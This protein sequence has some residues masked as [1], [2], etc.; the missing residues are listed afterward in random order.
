MPPPVNG[1]ALITVRMIQTL[2]CS[3]EVEA[4]NISPGGRRGFRKHLHKA[5]QT[6]RACWRIARNESR[7]RLSYLACEGDWGL[8]YTAA[9]VATARLFGHTIFLHHHS[10][11]YID[12]FSQ[13]MRLI[14]RIGGPK[15]LHIFLCTTMRD[16]FA[17][18]YGRIERCRIV[19]NAAFVEPQPE[20]K[21]AFGLSHPLR[22]GLLSNLTQEKG[23]YT[24]IDL[25]RRLEQSNLEVHGFLAG[26]IAD[27]NDKVNVSQAEKELTGSLTYMGPVFG[28]AKDQFYRNIDVFVFPTNYANEAQP[29][30]IFEALAAGNRVIAYDRGCIGNQIKGNGLAIPINE[31]FCMQASI[32]LSEL[33]RQGLTNYQSRQAIGSAFI[34]MKNSALESANGLLL[35]A[36]TLDRKVGCN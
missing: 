19:S 29:T 26:P 1:Y 17:R 8:F 23:L 22:I 15:L 31:D 4:I 18:R 24:F 6:L 3:A 2:K 21:I 13:L 33:V 10:F 5:A 16:R 9:L 7:P 20:I 25:L 27:E 36:A 14:L 28:D 34:D 12:R 32:Y 30:V 11:S 35:Q